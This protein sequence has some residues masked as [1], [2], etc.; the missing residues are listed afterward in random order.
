MGVRLTP[1]GTCSS[2]HSGLLSYKG[3]L[4]SGIALG[5]VSKTSY[6]YLFICDALFA[7]ILLTIFLSMEQTRTEN[8]LA[9]IQKKMKID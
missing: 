3:I 5:S 8:S 4:L 2:L 6:R 9:F 1:D 7:R